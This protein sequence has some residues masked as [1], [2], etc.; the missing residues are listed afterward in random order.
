MQSRRG[1]E[2]FIPFDKSFLFGFLS[3]EYAGD[4]T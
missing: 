2:E 4:T 1:K 3:W